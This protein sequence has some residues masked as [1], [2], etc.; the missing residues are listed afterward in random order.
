M[1]NTIEGTDGHDD[2]PGTVGD[3][4]IS[5]GEG[6][7]LSQANDGNDS[8]FGAGGDDTL[9][10]QGGNDLIYGQ[11][12]NDVVNGNDGDDYVVGNEGNDQV[13][14]EAGNDHL[15]GDEGND[16]LI[17]GTG[18]DTLYGGIDNDELFGEGDNDELYGEDGDDT[19][20]G[21]GG[22]DTLTGGAGADAFGLGEGGADLITDFDTTTGIGDGIKENNDRVDLSAFYNDTTL[23]A[24]NL[25]NPE[26]QYDSPLQ[27]LRAE[28]STGVLTSANGVR[29]Q[30]DGEAVDAYSLSA[31]NTNVT[32]FTRG[33][34]I[35]TPN[36]A[37]AIE[38]LR[39]GDLVMTRDHGPQPIRWIG[40][41]LLSCAD[42]TDN[43]KLRPVRIS[44]G[45][46][47]PDI[48]QSDLIVSP[49]HRILVRSNIAQKMF[50]THEVLVAAKQLL[51]VTGIDI[52]QKPGGV[53]YFHILFDRHE[54]VLSNNAETESL[55]TGPEAMKS[56]GSAARAEIFAI[57]PELQEL[58]YE[59]QA[60]R[61]LTS[62]RLARKLAVRHQQNSRALVN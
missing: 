3:D 7:D 11:T 27:W 19:L 49:Q 15:R 8:I 33:T 46:L 17:G 61:L 25:A 5:A 51:Q 45:A 23:A 20:H 14:G 57:F 10:G 52:D 22:D 32:C 2:I 60:A 4:Y 59:P 42:L 16:I 34:L 44:A 29:I 26:N 13:V 9:Y 55:F 50:G 43:P 21:Q 41:R 31:E 35:G 39:V 40:S 54:V 56:I 62:G 48:P 6:N 12:G 24:W 37:V 30:F 1:A 38:N 53:E 28:Q 18:E 36:G 47:G 58:D